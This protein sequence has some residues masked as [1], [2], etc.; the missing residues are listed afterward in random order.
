MA[1][2]VP[3]TTFLYASDCQARND[4]ILN[5]IRSNTSRIS[6]VKLYADDAKAS[7]QALGTDNSTFLTELVAEIAAM[8]ANAA[9]PNNVE[10][11]YPD[12]PFYVQEL[13]RLNS[14]VR[15][16]QAELTFISAVILDLDKYYPR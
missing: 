15:Q 7:L 11:T 13:A 5:S 6:N 8:E 1:T 16:Y 3:R 2:I 14:F 10:A 4:L 12:Y 9:D